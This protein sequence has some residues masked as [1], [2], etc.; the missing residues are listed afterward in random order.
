[1]RAC[2]NMR[3]RRRAKTIMMSLCAAVAVWYRRSGHWEKIPME[4]QD[5]SGDMLGFDEPLTQ[6]VELLLLRAVHAE[7]PKQ[8]EALLLR[9]LAVKPDNLRVL[10][11]L[12]RFYYHQHRLPQALEVSRQVMAVVARRLGFPARW[13]ELTANH[14]ANGVM[15]SIGLVRFFLT[16]LKAAGY[17]CLRCG[18]AEQGV[19]ML[20]KV[21]AMDSADRLGAK[22]L[23]EMM[24]AHTS[25]VTPTLFTLPHPPANP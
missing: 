21:V 12:Y 9:A 5:F 6:D 8:N 10:T 3:Q 14:V 20:E 17:I 13:Q 2:V 7:V 16:A 22:S 4:L 15:V 24:C 11:A 23:L 18:Q 19:A 1:M 25:S